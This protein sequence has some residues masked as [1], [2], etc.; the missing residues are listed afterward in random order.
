MSVDKLSA[1]QFY[2]AWFL[3]VMGSCFD[4][5]SASVPSL[6]RGALGC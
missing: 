4:P 3:W 5:L 6:Y 2:T 1:T